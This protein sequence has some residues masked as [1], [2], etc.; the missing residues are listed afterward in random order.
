MHRTC[1]D[2]RACVRETS[3]EYGHLACTICQAVRASREAECREILTV[4][5]PD[6]VERIRDLIEVQFAT[7]QSRAQVIL[8]ISGVLLSASALIATGKLIAGPSLHDAS[9]LMMAAGVT[10]IFS[11]AVA[12]GGVLRI[13]W[14]IP[15]QGHL[16]TWVMSRLAHRDHKTSA[17][18]V[19]IVLLL[20]S[21]VLYQTAV[22]IVLAQL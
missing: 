15:P 12:V 18:H 8:T 19:S 11:G 7:L 9:Q 22:T 21:M 17:L 5:G 1:L 20:V 2:S 16:E 14:P 10:N 3:H 6:R 4:S 13:R